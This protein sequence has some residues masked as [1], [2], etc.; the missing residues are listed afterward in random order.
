MKITIDNREFAA[1]EGT[2]ILEIADKNDI[3]IPHLCSHPELSPYGGCRL[4]IVEVE[5]IR[6]YPTA[7]TTQLT[8]GMVI[9][10]ETRTL[11][12]MRRDI[13]RLILS[14]HPTGCIFCEDE[15]ECSDFQTTIRKV[16]VTTGCR[17]C[18]RDK[19]CELRDVV[20]H[21]QVEDISLPVSYRALPEER[22]DPFFDRDYNLC[23]YC[24]RCVRICQEHRKSSV[25]SFKQRG[26]L[27]TIG[28]AFELTH[29]E[30]DCEFCGACVSVCPT[31]AMSEKGRKWAG[32]PDKFIP[33]VCPLCS[34][35]CDIQFLVKD[36]GVIGTLPMGDPH[37][38]GGE[39]CV[40]GRFCLSD[41]VNHP[42][43]LL[44]PT[45]KFP[46]GV[47]VVS[48]DTAFT[49]TGE[50]FKKADKGR[51]A[52][53][54]SPY[55]TSEE[56]AAAK[57]FSNEILNT[58]I[59]TSSALDN[60]F[61]SLLSLAEKSVKLERVEKSGAIVSLF[62]NGNYNYAPLTL[63]IKRAAESGIPYY[64]V[65]WLRDTTSRF[66]S[67]QIV[68]EQGEEREL[69]KKILEN[70]KGKPEDAGEMRDLIRVLRDAKPATIILGT[71]ILDHCDASS[72]IDSIN[73]IIDRTG[74]ELFMPNPYGNLYSLL[75]LSGIKTA[76]EVRELI[77]EGKISTI[78]MIGDCPFDER[79]RVDFLIY[80][81]VFPPPSALDVDVT[82]PMTMAGEIAGSFT[83]LKGD[84]RNFKAAAEKPESV[85][86][87]GKIFAGIAAKAGKRDVKFTR[88]EISKLIPGK[89]GWKFP[90]AGSEL[91]TSADCASSA[92]SSEYTLIQERNPHRY[93]SSS[94]NSLI[95]GIEIILPEDTVL[96]NPVDAEKIG[97]NRGDSL[98]LTAN[99]N[100]LSFPAATKKNV[101]PGYVYLLTSS[102]D[103]PFRSNP[104][105]V[106]L[107][108]ND[109]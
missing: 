14:E 83:D 99:G 31:G 16:G 52:V 5:G 9:R 88:K 106:K 47:G 75:S 84:I 11:R 43:R 3:Y 70:L 77:A 69:F 32:I 27:T 49:K 39:L 8:D 28:P 109:V 4:C 21:L 96:I 51:T 87:A 59:I 91:A 2:T 37:S 23:I 93:H 34:F 55:L 6:G 53:Y 40:K 22:Y 66:A 71:Q 105:P 68:P 36:N 80:Q 48:W 57:R 54:L 67:R 82:L 64:Q 95:V 61:G 45:Y 78:Y 103:L 94:L 50:R 38:T 108:R 89:A 62:L 86:D 24:A 30:A 1:R 15:E 10:T 81:G 7:C 90:K 60:N 102:S 20:D 18:A 29:V 72:I 44:S 85:L 42:D 100:S 17:W 107:R 56:M 46:E 58:D 12:E 97:L 92:S 33:S 19:D 25:I 41:L 13:L 74:A 76:E 79:P 65:G 104:C 63:A 98:T 73:K 26:R 101:S 35:N